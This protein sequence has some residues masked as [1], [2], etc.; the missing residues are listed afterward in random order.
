MPIPPENHNVE[1]LNKLFTEA[2][3]AQT[4]ECFTVAMEKYRL[5]LDYF[6]EAA[7]LHYN[8]GLVYYSLENFPAALDEFSLALAARPED[9]D[10]L[11]NSALCY[12][13]TG[14][15]RAA[16]TAYRKLL[17][18]MPD[19][20]D[21]WYNLAGCYLENHADELAVSCYQR[22]LELDS[23]YSAALNNL[24]YLYHRGG[25]FSQAESCYR[26]LLTLRPG[27]ESVNYMLASLCGT[28][29]DHAPQS[30]VRNFFDAYA[31]GFE[32]SLVD[33]LGYDNPR[34]LYECFK[35]CIGDRKVN[36]VYDHGL[37]LGCGTGLSGTAFQEIVTVLDGVDLS[38]KML[39]QAAEKHCYHSLH[40]DSILHYLQTTTVRYDFFL[41]A[42]VF[43]YVGELTD[44]FTALRAVARPDALFCFST[45]TLA[46]TGFQLQKTGRFA[47]SRNYIHNIAAGGG[48]S[49]L[50]AK[51]TRLR[52]ERERWIACDLWVLRMHPKI[53]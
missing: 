45:E 3:D 15:Y 47:Y 51:K 20:T 29:L 11:F 26:K 50:A 4:E 9:T 28:P 14:D 13:K 30:Y 48:W 2:C 34:Q 44:I 27:D 22:V 31:A 18:V 12:K 7:V 16:I 32:K 41:A 36:D 46:S 19:S 33:E 40:Q 10:A 25:D 53:E 37:D 49:V 42:D 24:A 52:K 39:A 38:A 21:C 17:E 1:E 35:G 43:I 5:L 6:P 8:L 23:E